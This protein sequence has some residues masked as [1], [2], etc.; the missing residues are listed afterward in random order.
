MQS[1]VLK[2]I[3]FITLFLTVFASARAQ[4]Y[5]LTRADSLFS[6]KRYT[7]SFEIY[8]YIFDRQQYTPAMLLKMAYV[9]EGLNHV[10][11]SV[12]FLSLYYQATRDEAARVKIQEM[13]D[14][15]KL[16]GYNFNQVDRMVLLYQHYRNTISA[17]FAAVALLLLALMYYLRRRHYNPVAVMVMLI[18][19]LCLF[20]VHLNWSDGRPEAIIASS[21]TY[22]MNGPSAG[23][24][25]VTVAREGHQVVVLG[26]E[27]IW[28]HVWW[29]SQDAYIKKD[30]LLYVKL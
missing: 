7:Q 4:T 3:T 19:L 11:R 23:A 15:F 8:Q 25:V 20:L 2:N 29:N 1:R 13:V 22:V 10:A 27:D 14:R 18:M 17:A 12:Y 5:S 16:D 21:N 6:Q 26:E 28:A 24:S 30:N 9:E